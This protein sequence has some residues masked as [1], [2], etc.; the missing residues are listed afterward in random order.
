M[1]PKQIYAALA[2][3]AGHKCH[4]GKRFLVS[5]RVGGE[6]RKIIQR[7]VLTLM[8]KID[9]GRTVND[10]ASCYGD[11]PPWIRRVAPV[12]PGFVSAAPGSVTSEIDGI[13]YPS[14]R[15]YQNEEP[16]I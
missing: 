16:P 2:K 4:D 13:V 11:N 3:I 9:Y 10:F 6:H 7:R 5:E 14:L 1:T 15:F 8:E 12:D